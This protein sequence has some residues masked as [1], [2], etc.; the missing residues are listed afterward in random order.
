MSFS[1]LQ[2]CSNCRSS[3]Q[4]RFFTNRKWLKRLSD[5]PLL[6]R[7][8][9]ADASVLREQRATLSSASERLNTKKPAENE[10]LCFSQS[11]SQP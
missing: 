3:Q 8:L 4:L 9:T 2:L 7:I 10:C 5:V 11:P 1:S 6:S